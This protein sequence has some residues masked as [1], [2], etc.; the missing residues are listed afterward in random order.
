[1]KSYPALRRWLLGA[2]TA[3]VFVAVL[4]VAAW[5]NPGGRG[6]R[7]DAPAGKADAEH[8]W[9]LFGGSV[10]R[11]LVNTVE[12][13][14]PDDWDVK[15]GKNIKWSAEMGTKA[16]GGPVISGGKIFIGTNNDNPRDPKIT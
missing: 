2:A 1:M 12:K 14:M 3:F 13:N 10:G 6:D 11:N 5:F 16:Y 4:A 9:P 15:T 7:R 8:R